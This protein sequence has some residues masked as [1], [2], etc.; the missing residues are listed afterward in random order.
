M[1]QT[2]DEN[3]SR[4][5]SIPSSAEQHKNG[6]IRSVSLLD[7]LCILSYKKDQAA[8]LQ[9]NNRAIVNV[10]ALVKAWPTAKLRNCPNW[11]VC[12]KT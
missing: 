11:G 5:V 2:W 6:V 7:T 10:E 4:N 3:N 12:D 9:G 1:L 8:R